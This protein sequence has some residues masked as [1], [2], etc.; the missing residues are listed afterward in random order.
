MT[1]GTGRSPGG[2]RRLALLALW[3]GGGAWAIGGGAGCAHTHAQPPPPASVPPTKPPFEQGA[4]TRIPVASTPQGL[5]KE[6]AVRKI[7]ERLRARGLLAG[8]PIA[9]Q[10]DADTRA[11]LAKFQKQEGLPATGLPSYETA[12]HLGLDLDEIFQTTQH[13]REPPP[14]PAASPP[15]APKP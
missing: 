13:P 2:L 9:D 5:L 11:A 1:I 7:Q 15:A 14:S 4:Q 8:D 12:R 3:C 6:G 10:L